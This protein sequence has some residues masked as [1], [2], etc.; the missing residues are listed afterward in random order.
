M[1]IEKKQSN[2]YQCSS[3]QKSFTAL[4]G[5]IFQDTKLPLQKWFLAIAMFLDAKKGIVA[6]QL[7]ECYNKFVLQWVIKKTKNYLK[8]L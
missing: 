8:Y 7:G 2:R 5:T 6:K 3:C 1:K 4:V